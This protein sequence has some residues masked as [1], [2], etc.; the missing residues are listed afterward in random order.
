M[1]SGN[2]LLE[3]LAALDVA[4]E[5]ID[6]VVLS[7]LH[8]DHAGGATHYDERRQFVPAFPRA[9]H[10]VGRIEWQDAVLQAPEL[11]AAYPIENLAP[12][13]EAS[14]VEHVEGNAEIVP[15]LRTRLTGGHTRGHMALVFE[16][17]GQG[18]L[19]IGDICASTAH[20]H[21]LWNLSY[22]TYP[23]ETR[24]VK[25]Q[26]L[27]EAAQR[28]WWVIWPHDTRVAAA[29]VQSHPKRGFVVV[30]PRASL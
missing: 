10:I 7:H 13:A 30:D 27:A 12:L 3:S 20:L 8:F 5:Q 17:E 25:P 15:G 14:L 24:R 6:L 22:D 4:P 9:R 21:P 18:A 19:F 16:S 1:Q 11:Q 2:P 23:L 26:L 29:R 28:D